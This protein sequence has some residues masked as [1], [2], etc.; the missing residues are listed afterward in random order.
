VIGF[1]L[2]AKTMDVS[3]ID[4]Q[5]FRNGLA[6]AGARK[7]GNPPAKDYPTFFLKINP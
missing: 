5:D 4:G 6:L 3:L 2:P 1:C 7:L